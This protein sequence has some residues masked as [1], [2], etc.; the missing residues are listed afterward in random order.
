MMTITNRGVTGDK[1]L[2]FSCIFEGL[3]VKEAHSAKTVHLLY[4]YIFLNLFSS[5]NFVPSSI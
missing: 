5:A 2:W 1:I 4:I 3:C